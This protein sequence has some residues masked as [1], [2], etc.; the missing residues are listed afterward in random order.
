MEV[1][2]ILETKDSNMANAYYLSMQ[3][4]HDFERS[5]LPIPYIYIP[6]IYTL[7]PK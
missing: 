3:M 1:K 2:D 5:F 6:Y 7:L 4:N